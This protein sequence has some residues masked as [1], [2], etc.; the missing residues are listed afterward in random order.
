M[1]NRGA[2]LYGL[3]KRVLS[4]AGYATLSLGLI[5]C[6]GDS[7]DSHQVAENSKITIF[8]TNDHHS[9]LDGS[10]YDLTIGGVNTRVELGGFARIAA[11][12]KA[13]RDEK[14]LVLNSGELAGTL[15]FSL[16]GGEPD[17]KL[18]NAL[19]L[20]AYQLGNHEFDEGEQRLRKLIDMANF[21][22]LSS[23]LRPTP[24]SPLFGAPIKPYLIKEINGEKIG[25]I[26]VIKVAKTVGSSMVTEAVEFFDE[27]ESVRRNVKELQ[28]QG[29]NKI[30]VL[31]HLGFKEDQELASK[32][33]GIDVI[34]G[35]D[36]HDL[37]DS[38]GELS[39]LGLQ[40][41]G[42]YPT[43]QTDL[44]GK[45]VYIAQAWAHAYGVGRLDVEFDS[46]GDVVSA[47]GNMQLLIDEPFQ[48]KG[49]DGKFH[50]PTAEQTAAIKSSVQASRTLRLQPPDPAVT[51]LLAPYTTELDNF[52]TRN[53]GE[54]LENMSY[55]RI[56]TAFQAG[57][58]PTGSYAAHVVADSF[59][60]FSP[61][62]DIAIQNAGGVRTQFLS[63]AFSVADAYTMLPFSNTVGTIVISGAEVIAVLEDATE[64]AL[65]STSS[66]AFPYASH[67]RF[68]VTKGGI[69]GQRIS[70][71][72]VKDRV[73]GLWSPID[74]NKAYKV[75]TNS[76]TAMGKDGYTTFEKAIA[77]DPSI[78]EDTHIE[79]AVPLVEYF[80]RHLKDGKLETLNWSEFSLKSVR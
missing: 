7:D 22:V 23:N 46:K 60:K 80:T 65:N 62:S 13:Q 24:A 36:T 32:V 18:F 72:E 44:E 78:Y 39:R 10:S 48:V 2:G 76:F 64:Y 55:D 3:T 8:H 33:A 51:A 59:L 35:G 31:S 49:T 42:D 56:P 28:A 52:R 40:P 63:G 16:F 41:S 26:G 14:S 27:V 4:W 38:T 45:K 15:Y 68:D 73:S 20:D 70:N 50:A 25:V 53:I 9:Y 17:F 69:K 6:G 30:V 37:L 11:A 61:T 21:P 5:A 47:T 71:V 19:G 74:L 57:Q 75:V 54:V 67:L 79:Y 58:K 77:A 34:I 29:I 66:G 12:V 43:V 1:M